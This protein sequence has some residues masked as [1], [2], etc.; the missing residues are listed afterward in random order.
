MTQE[1]RGSNMVGVGAYNERL[2]LSLI[3]GAGALSKSELARSTKL[4]AQTLTALVGRLEAQRLVIPNEPRRG[5]VGQ[6]S[7]PYSLNPDG[8]YSLGLK[9]GRRSFELVLMNFTGNVVKTFRDVYEYPTPRRLMKFLRTALVDLSAHTPKQQFAKIV[10]LGVA[11]PGEL[12]N[13]YQEMDAPQS[14]MDKWRTFDVTAAIREVVALPILI[15]NDA[16]AACV[17]ELT[18]G[19]HKPSGD[20]QYFYIGTFLGGGLVLNGNIFNGSRSN[21]GAVGSMLVPNT[22]RAAGSRAAQLLTVA[23]IITLH[24]ELK[25]LKRDT[26]VLWDPAN[27]DGIDDVLATWIE[28]VSWNLAFASV[29]SISVVDVPRVVIDGSIPDAV[30]SAIVKRTSEIVRVMPLAGLEPFEISSGT[31]GPMARAVGAASIP[32]HE[33]FSRDRDVLL[34]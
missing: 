8:A 21:A 3:R 6:P 11:M 28:S 24:N 17:A 30:R 25:R 10:G 4:S 34:K 31:L 16:T 23:S 5:R 26:S 33:I 27:W 14:E 19:A 7:V 1:S 20:F 29:N 15:L 2:V 18:F 9:I 12:W 32:L 13:W 22:S